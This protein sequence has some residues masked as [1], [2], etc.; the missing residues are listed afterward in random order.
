MILAIFPFIVNRLPSIDII[1][2]IRVNERFPIIIFS[3]ATEIVIDIVNIILIPLIVVI[4]RI[5]V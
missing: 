2:T 5:D 4:V 3:L 1:I